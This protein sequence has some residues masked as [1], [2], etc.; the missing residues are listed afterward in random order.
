MAGASLELGAN[1]FYDWLQKGPSPKA[2]P[3]NNYSGD[4]KPDTTADANMDI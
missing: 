4:V 2:Q 3:K 1:N